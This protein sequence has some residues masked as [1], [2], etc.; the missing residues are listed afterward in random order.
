MGECLECLSTH[1]CGWYNV[2]EL[3]THGYGCYNIPEYSTFNT[4]RTFY[5]C[6]IQNG[7]SSWDECPSWILDFECIRYLHEHGCPWTCRWPSVTCDMAAMYGNL[8]CLRY[9]HRH[10]CPW[11]NMVFVYAYSGYTNSYSEINRDKCAECFIYAFENN[12]PLEPLLKYYSLNIVETYTKLCKK[13]RVDAAK[14]RMLVFN[15]EL[16]ERTKERTEERTKERTK[17]RI[18]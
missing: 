17:E 5:E 3:N 7:S 4:L 12:C 9:A 15:N 13:Y 8:K 16:M 10:G 2:P 6:K 1:T 14:R 11:T 18:K